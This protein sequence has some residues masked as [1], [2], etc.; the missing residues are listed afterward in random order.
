FFSKC[1]SIKGPFL[2]ERGMAIPLYID[3]LLRRRT[4]YL[5]VRLFLRVLKPLVGI[6]QGDTG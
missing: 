1:R 5:S 4:M 6:P 2:R 3:Y